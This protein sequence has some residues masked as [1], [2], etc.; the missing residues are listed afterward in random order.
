MVAKV[1]SQ[2]K[3]FIV[4]PKNEIHKLP[5]YDGLPLQDKKYLAFS[6][7]IGNENGFIV[8]SDKRE[9]IEV[10]EN[11]QTLILPMGTRIEPLTNQQM[12]DEIR[13]QQRPSHREK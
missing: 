8:R 10:T 1:T 6:L 13:A 7:I 12:E 2:G 3:T 11:C 5:E 4:G 9:P